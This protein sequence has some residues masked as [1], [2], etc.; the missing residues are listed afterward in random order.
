MFVST[1]VDAAVNKV[2]D[3]VFE[4]V[5]DERFSLSNF[6]FGGEGLDGEDAPDGACWGGGFGRGE[7]GGGVIE[8]GLDEFDGGGRF[9]L[10]AQG[11]GG[12]RVPGYC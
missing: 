9:G 3:I 1:P 10:E 12:G 8:V 4:G 5:V 6:V 2:A 7:E 11:R